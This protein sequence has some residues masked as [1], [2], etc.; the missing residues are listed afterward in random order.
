MV[1]LHAAPVLWVNIKNSRS[2][3]H[4][5]VRL[6]EKGDKMRYLSKILLVLSVVLAQQVAMAQICNE[7]ITPTTPDERFIDRGDGTV[8]DKHTGLIWMRCSLGQTWNEQGQTCAGEAIKYTWQQALQAAD[9]YTF[10]GSDAWRLPNVK[11]LISIVEE[12]CYNPAINLEVF[13]ATPNSRGFLTSS[14]YGNSDQGPAW[15]VS[16]SY[17]GSGY[18]D[19]FNEYVRLVRPDSN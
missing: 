5:L 9:G 11:E 18:Y 7:N 16:F 2:G 15:D 19:I 4:K 10:A 1:L 3:G 12:G 17:G 8:Q 13:P 6:F 14:P